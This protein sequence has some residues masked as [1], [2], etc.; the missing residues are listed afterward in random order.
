MTSQNAR[1]LLVSKKCDLADLN[2]IR[3][4]VHRIVIHVVRRWYKVLRRVVRDSVGSEIREEAGPL[5][6]PV[7]THETN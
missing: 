4:D 2:W 3:S 6:F 1:Q 7:T 5:L